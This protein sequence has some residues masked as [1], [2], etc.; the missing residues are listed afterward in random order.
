MSVL[1]ADQGEQVPG[2]VGKHGPV[3]LGVV[4]DGEEQ[5]VER[6]F[7]SPSGQ[8]GEGFLG[9]VGLLGP[10]GVA[11]GFTTALARRDWLG[12][13]GAKNLVAASAA[14]LNPARI[15]NHHLDDRQW[16]PGLGQLARHV[17]RRGEGH[18]GVEA[19]VVFAAEGAGVGQGGG[20]DQAFQLGALL[21]LLD[22]QADDLGGRSFLHERDQR[23]DG[24]ELETLGL[25]AGPDRGQ[26]HVGRGRRPHGGHEH[27]APDVGQEFPPVASHAHRRLLFQG[28]APLVSTRLD[29]QSDLERKSRPAAIVDAARPRGQAE[30]AAVEPIMPALAVELRATATLLLESSRLSPI[31]LF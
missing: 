4:L 8:R 13:D 29:R 27:P 6:L 25:V 18:H 19:H 21:E 11:E 9:D 20:G 3:D 22:D 24:P 28:I 17:E 5:V 1:R 14:F 7:R 31:N 12:G 2:A 26:P 23:L 30:S 16:A 10:H 15:A